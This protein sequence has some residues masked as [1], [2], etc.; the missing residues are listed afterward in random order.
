MAPR[1]AGS[2]LRPMA[3]A[4]HRVVILGGGVAALEV[5]LALRE[6]AEDRV[7]I[8]LLAPEPWFWYRPLSTIEPFGAQ[9]VQHFE[10]AAFARACSARFV[11]GATAVA[12]DADAKLV[13]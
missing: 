6:L 9:R 11:L 1:W 13:Y 10:L 3:S 7:D 2:T 8:D 4:R 12:V 5:M